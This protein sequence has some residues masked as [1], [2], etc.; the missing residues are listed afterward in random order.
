MLSRGGR[1]R[2]FK[3]GM[4]G[5]KAALYYVVYGEIAFLLFLVICITLHPGFVLKRDEGGMSNY[6]LHIKTAI[7]YT[8]ALASLSLC[9]LGAA[10][11]YSGYGSTR[12]PRKIVLGYGIIVGAV[13]LST[14]AYTFNIVLTDIHFGLGAVLVGFTGVSSLWMGVQRRVSVWTVAFLVIQLC[15]D[16]G[17]LLAAAGAFHALFAAEMATNLG[18]SALMIRTCLRV[19]RG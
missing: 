13:L 19:S 6:G 10:L 17:A 16:V 1:S 8:L 9:S 15:G 2:V 14:Y 3:E 7:P 5:R 18:F 4:P 11:S 12:V